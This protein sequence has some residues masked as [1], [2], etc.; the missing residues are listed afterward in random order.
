MDN[1]LDVKLEV[2]RRIV[3][4][5]PGDPPVILPALFEGDIFGR[6]AS[7]SQFTTHGPTAAKLDVTFGE[8]DPVEM[9]GAVEAVQVNGRWF[10][11]A[12]TQ[13][14]ELLDAHWEAACQHNM[15]R[16]E[17]SFEAPTQ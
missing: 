17:A 11:A 12:P 10:I 3:R 1:K 5:E 2:R 14:T 6:P 4:V 16:R 9:L 15:S 13:M 8:V 7:T